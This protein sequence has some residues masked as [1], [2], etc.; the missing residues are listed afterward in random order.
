MLGVFRECEY[1]IRSIGI[2]RDVPIYLLD[3][4]EVKSVPMLDLKSFHNCQAF[5]HWTLDLL[6][7]DHLKRAGRWKGAGFSAVLFLGRLNTR[8]NILVTALHEAERIFRD[9]TEPSRLRRAAIHA[10]GHFKALEHLPA[11]RELADCHPDV[12]IRI[13]AIAELGN[14]RDDASKSIF[15]E[16]HRSSH[17]R[18]RSAGRVA[19]DKLTRFHESQGLP[20]P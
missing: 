11:L 3:A 9:E 5:T 20:G 14:L 6:L 10:L 8:R 4:G 17:R 13:A 16:A 2:C 7:K 19:M 12:E 15:I 1:L 18:L